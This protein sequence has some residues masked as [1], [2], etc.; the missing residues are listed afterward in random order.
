MVAIEDFPLR[1]GRSQT[2]ILFGVVMSFSFR[3]RLPGGWASGSLPDYPKYTPR[4]GQCQLQ[5]GAAFIGH[6]G[7]PRGGRV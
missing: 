7:T 3:S 2:L 1:P 4:A 5:C 6:D